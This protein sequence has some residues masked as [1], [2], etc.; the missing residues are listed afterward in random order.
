MRLANLLGLR[1]LD[2]V[3]INSHEERQELDLWRH[4]NESAALDLPYFFVQRL[5]PTGLV[6]VRGPSG[7]CMVV[8]VQDICNVM[9]GEPIT[10]RA[11]PRSRFLERLKLFPKT[12]ATDADYELALVRYVSK[13]RWNRVDQVF[14]EFF[15][16]QLNEGSSTFAGPIHPDDLAML[17]SLAVRTRMPV[18][19]VRR[20]GA[21]YSADV[22][23]ETQSS[24]AS[25][26]VQAFRRCALMRDEQRAQAL[27][28]SGIKP[29]TRA[30]LNRLM[31]R[32]PQIF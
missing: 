1:P 18:T 14:V 28:E 2:R 13:D 15:E 32:A 8:G 19:A 20:G 9:R 23:V 30:A 25:A 24:L 4:R 29:L 31:A 17:Q 5:T 11:M 12:A 22:G 7:R 16:C 10:V 27:R 21:A 6:E 3:Q 26:T